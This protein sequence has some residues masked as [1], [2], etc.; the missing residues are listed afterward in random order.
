[1]IDWSLCPAA[2]SRPGKL[3]GAW[4]FR[5]TRVPLE[6]LFLYLRRGV[7]VDEFLDWFEGVSRE[8]VVEVLE[9]VEEQTRAS[10]RREA[11]PVAA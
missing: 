9:F 8:Q 7:S 1:M 11:E 6:T 5:G 3:S 4:V 2:E 10:R